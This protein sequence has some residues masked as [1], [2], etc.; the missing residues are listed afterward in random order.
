MPQRGGR[1]SVS[2]LSALQIAPGLAYAIS[3]AIFGSSAEY[4]ALALKSA[5]HQSSF[6]WYVSAMMALALVVSLRLPREARHL[7]HAD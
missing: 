2:I 3:S 6:D 5:G 1:P 4:V 7:R